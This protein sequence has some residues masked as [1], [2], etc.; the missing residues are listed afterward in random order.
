MEIVKISAIKPA[1]YNPRLLTEEAKS[2]LIASIKDM[3]FIL[4]VIVNRTNDT[5]IAG[6]QRTKCATIL[7]IEEVP[8]YFVDKP[9][10][11]TD[12]IL[13]NQLHNG[14]D[15][16]P[17]QKGK[18]QGEDFNVGIYD[19][20]PN[21][22]FE[23]GGFIPAFTN[24][25][26]RL[27]LQY[28][29]VFCAIVCDGE[30]VLGNS[31]VKACRTLNCGVNVSII[32]HRKKSL[33][34]HHFCKEYGVFCYTNIEKEDFVQ[35]LAQPRRTTSENTLVGKVSVKGRAGVLYRKLVFPYLNSV[36]DRTLRILDFGC[37][38]AHSINILKN[39]MG[40]KNAIGLEF[41]NLNMRGISVEYGQR[42]ITNL[43]AD[44]EKNGLF[45]VVVCEAVVNSVNCMEARDAVL[46]CLS[47]FCK[48][49]GKIFLSGRRMEVEVRNMN[50]SQ[51]SKAFIASL[52]FFDKNGFTGKLR[53][54]VWYFQKSHTDEE[55]AKMCKDFGFLVVKQYSDAYFGLDIDKQ[56]QLPSNQVTEA[57]KY[58]FN[59]KLPNG[60]RYGRGEDIVKAVMPFYQSPNK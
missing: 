52:D 41:F 33:F 1:S 31:Y 50:T 35:G 6:H 26:C 59:L 47:A 34:Y 27:I 18:F 16:E 38:K 28:G 5:I 54:G 58:E 30:V 20:V 2:N 36:G 40:Y 53:E 44:I 39:E 49:N 55:V 23:L 22:L 25:I 51:R 48:P 14:T 60:C 17:E 15:K 46:G 10:S 32:D 56:F 42:M 19:G 29:N 57:L 21:S 3:G 24:D 45:D 8:A 11:I 13:F 9:I 43:I 4:P 12:E 7:G 37:G